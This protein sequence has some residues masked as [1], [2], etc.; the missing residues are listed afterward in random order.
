[1]KVSKFRGSR[2]LVASHVLTQAL[3]IASTRLC[4]LSWDQVD[5]T[6]LPLISRKVQL[7]WINKEG[8]NHVI[9]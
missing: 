6:V 5:K 3:S 4:Q 2:F 7:S 8:T 1:M 9:L